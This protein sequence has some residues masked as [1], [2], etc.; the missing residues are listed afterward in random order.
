MIHGVD[1]ISGQ[2][3]IYQ[4]GLNSIIASTVFQVPF[5]P[6]VLMLKLPYLGHL[7]RSDSLENTLM[8][9]KA[10]GEGDERGDWE[11]T[12]ENLPGL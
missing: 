3:R 7:M 9:G 5:K 10:E 1:N 8:L 2:T 12:G 6:Q 11:K 4:V